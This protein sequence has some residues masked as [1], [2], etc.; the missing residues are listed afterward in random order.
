MSDSDYAACTCGSAWFDLAEG[1]TADGRALGAV[2][3]DEYGDVIAY[4]GVLTCVEC[5]EVFVPGTEGRRGSGP[6]LRL[7]R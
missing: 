1:E 5:G 2:S 6:A 4:S 3:V 7:V